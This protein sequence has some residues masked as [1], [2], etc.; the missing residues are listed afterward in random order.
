MGE[1]LVAT[2]PVVL[3]PH[4]ATVSFADDRALRYR[5]YDLARDMTLLA[6][7]GALVAALAWI[8]YRARGK[9]TAL[10][11]MIRDALSDR[12]P[13]IPDLSHLDGQIVPGPPLRPVPEPNA[14]DD[15]GRL[16][17][18]DQPPSVR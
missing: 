12:I 13:D 15:L 8:G 3:M 18:R 9:R 5:Y 4:D 10:V 2:V 17:D 7:G 1:Y 6:S 14:P 16:L 11:N